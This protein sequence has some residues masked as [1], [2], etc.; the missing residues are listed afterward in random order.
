MKY[1]LRINMIKVLKEY[2]LKSLDWILRFR[3]GGVDLRSK[4]YIFIVS[5][6]SLLIQVAK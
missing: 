3:I 6:F 5:N 2:I 4:L 1:T